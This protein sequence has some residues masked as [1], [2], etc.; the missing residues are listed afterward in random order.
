M[1]SSGTYFL[2]HGSLLAQD[3]QILQGMIPVPITGP[4]AGSTGTVS[5]SFASVTA[6][7]TTISSTIQDAI[8]QGYP[9]H[10]ATQGTSSSTTLPQHSTSVPNQVYPLGSAPTTVALDMEMLYTAS[11]TQ[12]SFAYPAQTHP[13]TGTAPQPQTQTDLTMQFYP[14]PVTI[15]HGNSTAASTVYDGIEGQLLEPIPSWLMQTETQNQQ[16]HP[17]QGSQDGF[18]VSLESVTASRISQG[19]GDAG[20]YR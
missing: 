7:A 19:W 18:H 12:N 20:G 3:F 11:S 8:I 2:Q 4:L 14:T 9:Q 15:Q 16:G 1:V 13:S 6:A 5:A 10:Q 17:G